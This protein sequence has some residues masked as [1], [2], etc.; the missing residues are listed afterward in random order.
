MSSMPSGMH[1]IPLEQFAVCVLHNQH[2][3]HCSTAESSPA[4]KHPTRS[5]V[6]VAGHQAQARLPALSTER[7]PAAMQG[8]PQMMI[9]RTA[10]LSGNPSSSSGCS[11]SKAALVYPMLEPLR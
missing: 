5:Q 9:R 4:L 7:D 8:T 10:Q 1:G 2:Q 11:T 3:I 6:A